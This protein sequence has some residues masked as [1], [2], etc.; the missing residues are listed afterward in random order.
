MLQAIVLAG[1]KG[2]RLW[3]LTQ[4]KPKPMVEVAG[5]PLLCHHLKWLC[6]Q[7]VQD[8]VVACGYRA[9]VIVKFLNQNSLNSLKAK[10]YIEDQPLGRGG[11]IKKAALVLPRP[12]EPAI[13]SQGDIIT[14][15][16]LEEA[17]TAFGNK[18]VADNDTR[19]LSFALR[20]R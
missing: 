6:G 19:P 1:G 17:A 10:C 5:K 16:P 2:E 18:I 12:K 9:E 4:D 13:I 15:I 8:V 14:D 3:P 7:G 20:R 11:A